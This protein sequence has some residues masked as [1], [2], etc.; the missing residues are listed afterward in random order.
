MIKDQKTL[1]KPRRQLSIRNDDPFALICMSEKKRN[2]ECIQPH[3]K[4]PEKNYDSVSSHS[5]RKS[6]VDQ[7][8]FESYMKQLT[9][10]NSASVLESRKSKYYWQTEGY[11][12]LPEKARNAIDQAKLKSKHSDFWYRLQNLNDKILVFKD[13][14]YDKEPM[15]EKQF[16]F[17]REQMKQ[18][19]RAEEVKKLKDLD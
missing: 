10:S 11:W 19:K 15:F 14:Y 3:H 12:N 9:Q 18:K 7:K 13:I 4:M 17:K 5:S 8:D 16:N 2:E 1:F 6:N